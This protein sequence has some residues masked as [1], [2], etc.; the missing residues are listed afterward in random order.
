MFPNKRDSKTAPFIE[1]IDQL[2]EKSPPNVFLNLPSDNISLYE[3]VNYASLA[4]N[5]GSSAGVELLCFGL[6]VINAV[7][8]DFLVA[9]IDICPYAKNEIELEQEIL[10]T[11]G[12]DIDMKY[13]VNAYRWFSF[14]FNRGARFV[15]KNNVPTFSQIRPKKTGM[16]LWLWNIAVRLV[17]TR[18]PTILERRQIANT[19]SDVAELGDFEIVLVNELSGLHEVARDTEFVTSDDLVYITESTKILRRKIATH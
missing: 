11:Y 8:Q 16:R 9:P 4:L 2:L 15:F 18:L 17:V 7:S 3:L 10:K 12:L 6:P 19:E 14:Q 13:T 5:Y 1:V